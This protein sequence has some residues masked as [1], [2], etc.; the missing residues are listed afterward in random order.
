MCGIVGIIGSPGSGLACPA[1]RRMLF[2]QAHRGPDDEGVWSETVSETEVLLGASRLAVLDGS[3]A[4]HQPMVSACGRF[5][6]AF[7]GEVYNYIELR[8]ELRALGWT[9]RS[10]CDTEVVLEALRLWGKAALTRFNGM[11][12]LAFIDLDRSSVLLARDRFGVK[13]LYFYAGERSLLFASEI[14]AILEGSGTR[15]TINATVAGRFLRQHRLDADDQTFFAGIEKLAA[16]HYMEIS[17]ADTGPR[18]AAQQ[19]Y[20]AL[21]PLPP[22]YESPGDLVECVRNAFT[23]AVKLR[24]RSDVPVGVLL[25]G[26]VDSSS[27]AA[28]VRAINGRD[29]DL[30]LLSAVATTKGT[31]KNPGST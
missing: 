11:W 23:D 20:W 6:L 27:I 4:G 19:P 9:F 14:K 18:C 3:S 10:S 16:G 25:S 5:V 28:T 17:I 12:G 22:T 31:V 8:N 30:H 24:L 2:A 21:S 26:G 29:C 13:P 7:N 1:L 15:F